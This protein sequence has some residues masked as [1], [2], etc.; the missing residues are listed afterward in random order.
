MGVKKGQ[1]NLGVV[2]FKCNKV[3]SVAIN[4]LSCLRECVIAAGGF[5]R[6]SLIL[7]AT[8]WEIVLC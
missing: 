2:I 4:I 5:L 3:S 8:F 6:L 1:D 7:S